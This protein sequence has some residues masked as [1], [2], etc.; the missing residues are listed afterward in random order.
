MTSVVACYNVIPGMLFR[1]EV[2]CGHRNFDFLIREHS[3]CS[4][5]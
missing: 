3:G 2:Y 1:T 4:A 5:S